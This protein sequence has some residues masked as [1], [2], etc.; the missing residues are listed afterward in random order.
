MQ[1]ETQSNGFGKG[2]ASY[3]AAGGF[4]GLVD[5]VERFYRVMDTAPEGARIRALHP[6]DLTVSKDKLARFLSGW[7]GGPRL[8]NETYGPI[9]IPAAH[10]HLV[11]GE[12]GRDAWLFCMRQALQEVD[13]APAFKEYLIGALGVPAERIRSVARVS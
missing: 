5:L 10:A 8:F 4:E 2:D 1:I 7:L 13:Y 12:E 11:V 3:R 9:S 6:K